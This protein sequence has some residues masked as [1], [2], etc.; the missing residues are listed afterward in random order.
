MMQKHSYALIGRPATASGI[1]IPLPWDDDEAEEILF[2]TLE[3]LNGDEVPFEMF[4]AGLSWR[5]G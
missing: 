3:E 4:L 2:D 5:A 1:T